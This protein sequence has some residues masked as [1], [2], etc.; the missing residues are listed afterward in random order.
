MAFDALRMGLDPLHLTEL[1]GYLGILP[2][3]GAVVYLAVLGVQQ[4]A[5]GF[6]PIAYIIGAL[7][8]FGPAVA[9]LAI[10]PQ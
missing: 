1:R 3:Y 10:G 6:F 5:R 8:V 2:I 9:L 7:A 4:V